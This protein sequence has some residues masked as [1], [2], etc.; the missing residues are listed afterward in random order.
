MATY[1]TYDLTLGKTYYENGFFNLGVAVDRFIRPDNGNITLYL[2][3]N[4]QKIV[5]KVNR[6]ANQNGTPRIF[7]GAVLR[8][9]FFKNYQMGDTV[10]IFIESPTSISVI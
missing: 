10:N 6:D 1:P 7:G 5:G 2:G 8:D 3:S 4:R 9:W